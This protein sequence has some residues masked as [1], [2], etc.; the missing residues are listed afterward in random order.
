MQY[1][2]YYPTSLDKIQD[3]KNNNIDICVKIKSKN[4][5]FV[6]ATLD[7]LKEPMWMDPRGFVIPSA[8]V[9]LVDKLTK[10]TIEALVEELVKDESLLKIYGQD[11]R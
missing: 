2:I 8:P 1:S 3:I 5:T 7:N 11:L 4:Y 9:L 10:E 6:I